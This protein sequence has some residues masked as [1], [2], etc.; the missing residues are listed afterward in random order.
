[1]ECLDYDLCS[2]WDNQ[3]KVHHCML[4][5]GLVKRGM[6]LRLIRG[7][8]VEVEEVEHRGGCREEP[9]KVVQVLKPIY[10]YGAME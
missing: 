2:G 5:P 6:L 3:G 8:F 9:E 10:G 4:P 7:V 1:M